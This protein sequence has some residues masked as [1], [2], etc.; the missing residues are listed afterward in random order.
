MSPSPRLYV[1]IG[2][3]KTG[4]SY[5]QAA[6]L[7]NR[8]VMAEQGLDLVP[9][10]K[11]E[12]FELMLLVR[13]RY[14]PALDSASVRDSLDRFTALLGKAPGP[15]ALISQESLSAARPHQI[16]PLL[17]ACGDREVHV[18]ATVRDLGRQLPSTWQQVLKGGG[19]ASY[20]GFLRRARTRE[21]EGS[22]GRP[23]THLNIPAVLERWSEAVGGPER[24]NV[25]TVP[26][27]GSAPTA[28]LERYCSVLGV[29]PDRMVP[30]GTAVNTSLGRVQ[31]ELLRRVN[32]E[33][34]AELR[35]RQVYGNVGKRF[36]AAQV[37]AAQDGSTIRVP[38]EFRAWCEEVA[39]RQI[40]AIE[41]AGYAVT[42]DLADL[43]CQDEAF[44]DADDPPTHRDVEAAAVKALV[45]MLAIRGQAARRRG[46][47]PGTHDVAHAGGRGADGRH[48][49][50]ARTGRLLRRMRGGPPG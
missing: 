41:G 30:E 17:D 47:G 4:T 48:T 14:D 35:P 7:H 20:E 9:P 12:A 36:F 33:L 3:P 49:L 5:L 29:D 26:P 15:R 24:I 6:L 44:A 42:G 22:D 34:P 19:T 32:S 40:K 25:V 37:L 45:H 31:A 27:R 10:T 38:P 18:I 2:M 23:W 28:L 46:G 50:R 13:D 1:H 39:E 11:R 8:P 43:R 16:R 21:Q